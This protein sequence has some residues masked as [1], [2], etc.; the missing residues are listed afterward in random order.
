[1]I[2]NKVAF[3]KVEVQGKRQSR[4]DRLEERKVT[5]WSATH[6]PYS[7]KTVK[8]KN[9]DDIIEEERKTNE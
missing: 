9:E 8:S 5:S 3:D 1:M 4:Y 6:L 2:F 7:N